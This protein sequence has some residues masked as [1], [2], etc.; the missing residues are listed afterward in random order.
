MFNLDL[1]N[2][3]KIQKL[4]KE[5]NNLKSL[6]MEEE[7]SKKFAEDIG[8]LSEFYIKALHERIDKLKIEL[9]EKEE[10]NLR[11][12]NRVTKLEER[13]EE[14]EKEKEKEKER[15]FENLNLRIDIEKILEEF[16]KTKDEIKN[17]KTIN[18]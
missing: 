15:S 16:E 12:Q 4:E 7:L 17:K 14:K 2:E 8:Q 3:K 10:D 5:N 1:F 13:L 6:L 18:K 11:L 9:K